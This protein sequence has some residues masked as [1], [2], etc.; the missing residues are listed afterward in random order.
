ME[1]VLSAQAFGPRRQGK[2]ATF[3]K[4]SRADRRPIKITGPVE[5]PPVTWTSPK[6]L[7]RGSGQAVKKGFGTFFSAAVRS[8][9]S[10]IAQARGSRAMAGYVRQL[11]LAD[12]CL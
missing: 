11:R 4:D 9:S 8:D 5:S 1:A 3:F 2:T 7:Q 6:V 10:P 12:S